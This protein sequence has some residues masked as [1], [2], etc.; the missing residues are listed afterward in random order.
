MAAPLM[1]HHLVIRLPD[2]RDAWISY[3]DRIAA[4]PAR[5]RKGAAI[6]CLLAVAEGKPADPADLAEVAAWL[7]AHAQQSWLCRA[8]HRPADAADCGHD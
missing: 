3:R 8:S 2:G 4:N 5:G 6:R 7:D 1:P